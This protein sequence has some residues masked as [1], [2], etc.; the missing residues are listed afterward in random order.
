MYCDT[1]WAGDRTS[2]KSITGYV[3]TL[4]GIAIS[5]KSIKQSSIALLT[6][7]AEYIALSTIVIEVLWLWSLLQEAGFALNATTI[8]HT[9]NN[10]AIITANNSIISP[11]TKHIDI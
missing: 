7:K 11:W 9:D 6:V 10:G 8:I 3:I 2:H 5:W 1:D 4:N